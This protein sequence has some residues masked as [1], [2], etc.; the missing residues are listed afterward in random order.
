MAKVRLQDIQQQ[1]QNDL[2]VFLLVNSSNIALYKKEIRYKHNI[3]FLLSRTNLF[4][5]FNYA[6]YAVWILLSDTVSFLLPLFYKTKVC[7]SSYLY[8]CFSYRKDVRL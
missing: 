6:G 7:Y 4:S 8:Y 2:Q 5:L 3:E 1:E